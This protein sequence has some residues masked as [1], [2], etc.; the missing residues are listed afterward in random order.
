[1][2]QYYRAALRQ[3]PG[4]GPARIQKLCDYFGSAQQAWMAPKGDLFLCKIIPNPSVQELLTRRDQGYVEKLIQYCARKEIK[5]I[6]IE[7]PDYPERLKTIYDPPNLL[8]CSGQIPKSFLTIAIVGARS[9]SVYGKNVA[10]KLAS[11]L[12]KAGVLVVSGAA[13]GIDTAAHLGALEQGPTVAVLGC[14]I[15]QIYPPE[16]KVLFDKI[17]Q[18]GALI[19]EYPPGTL[20]HA[21]Y[22][23]ARNRIIAGLASGVLVVEAAE[24]SGSLITAEVALN[25]G[26]DVFAIPGSI[27][28]KLSRGTHYLIQ[29]GAKLVKDV[30]DI[31]EEYEVITEKIETKS[32][33]TEAEQKICD[34]LSYEKPTSVEELIGKL[35]LRPTDVTYTLLQ[36]ELSGWII[37]HQQGYIRSVKEVN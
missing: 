11:Q 28:S 27:F 24:K 29:Q 1:M 12:T 19:S 34:L 2:D 15:D 25:E 6:A 20:P 18:S 17:R 23:P 10:T 16:N 26:R 8:F 7:D 32:V 30:E 36:L 3:I 4:L 9:A 14:G 5:I 31:L 35:Q 21:A 13:R 37:P 22:F 33:L